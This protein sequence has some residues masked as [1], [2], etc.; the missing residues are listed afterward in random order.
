VRPAGEH[1]DVVGAGEV[2][3]PQRV[4]LGGAADEGDAA[5]VGRRPLSRTGADP[6]RRSPR[7]AYTGSIDTAGTSGGGW[8]F[9]TARTAAAS[10][11]RVP[12]PRMKT[13]VAGEANGR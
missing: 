1:D 6:R 8:P 4:A 5:G 13:R 7:G 11:R 2:A 9:V 12:S 3:R 10:R